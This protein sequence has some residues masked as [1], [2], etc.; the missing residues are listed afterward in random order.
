M[1][2]IKNKNLFRIL[3]VFF[4]LIQ[5]K[6][7]YAQI[8]I[9]FAPLRKIPS[10]STVMIRI[11]HYVRNKQLDSLLLVND[12]ISK[13]YLKSDSISNYL[14]VMN[15]TSANIVQVFHNLE[16]SDSIQDVAMKKAIERKDTLS[17]EYA[18]L[19]KFRGVNCFYLYEDAE[20]TGFFVRGYNL[21]KSM[22]INNLLLTDFKANVGNGYLNLGYPY[23]A[24]PYLE[25]VLK[26]SKEYNYPLLYMLVG[27]GIGNLAFHTDN[28]L[29]IEVMSKVYREAK[30]LQLDT[31]SKNKYLANICYMLGGFHMDMGHKD[32]YVKYSKLANYY[33]NNTI[34]PDLYLRI[35]IYTNN[36]YD[37]I[38]EKDIA[39]QINIINMINYNLKKYNVRSPVLL[40][41][42]YRVLYQSY[43]I[44]QL[45]DS[46]DYY[47]D[48]CIS[49]AG[50]KKSDER[51]RT[52]A[53]LG[54]Y[55]ATSKEKYDFA[56]KV[57]DNNIDNFDVNKINNDSV[58]L[59]DI[60]N[61]SFNKNYLPAFIS[62]SDYYYS[63]KDSNRMKNL[64][65]SL[66]VLDA[67]SKVILTNSGRAV[68]KSAGLQYSAI[69][70]SVFNKKLQTLD[71][72]QKE[73]TT[74]LYKQIILSNMANTQ[75]FYLQKQMAFRQRSQ[76]AENDSL[77]NRYFKFLILKNQLTMNYEQ[78]L[79]SSKP[80]PK[81]AFEDSS[82]QLTIALIKTQILMN[83]KDLLYAPKIIKANIKKIQSKIDKD[84]I[85]VN[86]Y[87][88]KDSV[89]Y[90][91]LL[92][93][94]N[95]KIIKNT[96]Y[97]E[98]KPLINQ[99][100]RQVK[101]GEDVLSGVNSKLTRLLFNGISAD[102]TK[103]SKL[104]IIP[105]KDLWKIPFETLSLN[106]KQMLIE[107]YAITYNTSINLWSISKDKQYQAAYSF[108]GIAPAFMSM[109][110]TLSS[111]GG[112][113]NHFS[114]LYNRSRSQM[115]NL[116]FS[117]EEVEE[118]ADKFNQKD[119]KNIVL[120]DKKATESS[121]YKYMNEYSIVHIATHGFV[122]KSNPM[123]TGIFFSDNSPQDDAYLFA[124]E[125]SNLNSSANLVVLSSCNSGSGI[126]ESSEG[127]NSLQR[128]F[129]L[130]GVPN[131]MASLWKVHDKKTMELMNSFYSHLLQGESYAVSLQ[132]AKKEAIKKGYLPLDWAGF[133]L[134]G[135]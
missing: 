54:S 52:F 88:S 86:Y 124:D 121:F 105:H 64:L 116:P 63:M 17:I 40:L 48:L 55:A 104:I 65:I 5:I 59:Q 85:I 36:L 125:I 53:A 122:S 114:L 43:Y 33:I 23:L 4:L 76:S 19:L 11:N 2:E 108:V 24:L 8:Q 71:A 32:E 30:T 91:A 118:I 74:M 28:E 107:D 131:V 95:L 1:I 133:I 34:I 12:E 69:Y 101:T 77:W 123:L 20:S 56:M 61:Y 21:L 7:S 22:H 47:K 39:E 120:T 73:D 66:K 130:S 81:I 97:R 126:L 94:D 127:I 87:V 37:A 29:G 102:I 45:S 3:L 14:F 68:K 103:K 90:T 46:A 26:E 112:G 96:N 15:Q 10:D 89:I 100:L 79:L 111:R 6:I 80:M 41:P 9:S 72:L 62:I 49:L 78:S 98:I 99:F 67:M 92:S 113:F 84:E 50:D 35:N 60:N 27:Q 42:A 93:R 134:M 117:K 110:S 13:R 70:E 106:G 75:A 119:L 115:S 57:I 38:D 25:D 31:N 58:L 132:Q 44:R 135:E 129:I 16:L 51:V 83:E 128:Y 18:I 109:D 82:W